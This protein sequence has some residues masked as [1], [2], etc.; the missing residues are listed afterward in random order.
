MKILSKLKLKFNLLDLNILS[1]SILNYEK[2]EFYCTLFV[3]SDGNYIIFCTKFSPQNA[4]N[5]I[6]G[7]WNL[8][9]KGSTPPKT[10]QE[11]E[12]WKA[13]CRYSQ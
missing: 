9:N 5:R 4:G 1:A 6:L 8:K 11:E 7:P 10:H 2:V 12:D 13:P 3:H